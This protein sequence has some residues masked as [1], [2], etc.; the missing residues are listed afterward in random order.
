MYRWDPKNELVQYFGHGN[1]PS[2][3]TIY[4]SDSKNML[5]DK[6]NPY[7]DMIC[8]LDTPKDLDILVSECLFL[9]PMYLQ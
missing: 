6:N 5:N 4:Y 8:I 3:Q 2:I 1:V 9:D 7:Y